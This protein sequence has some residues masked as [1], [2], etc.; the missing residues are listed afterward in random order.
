MGEVIQTRRWQHYH[1]CARICPWQVFW[2]RVLASDLERLSCLGYYVT[3]FTIEK[4][5]RKVIQ[6]QGFL[7]AALFCQCHS[8]PL[9]WPACLNPT[10]TSGYL[11]RQTTNELDKW[12]TVHCRLYSPAGMSRCIMYPHSVLTFLPSSSST[13]ELIREFTVSIGLSASTY[14]CPAQ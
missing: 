10:I 9:I 2:L 5:G 1:Y 8:C 4:L 6:I 12:R 11:G 13:L 7:M 14:N 3:V